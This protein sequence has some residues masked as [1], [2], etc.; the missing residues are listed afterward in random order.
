[1]TD[2]VSEMILDADGGSTDGTSSTFELEMSLS[3][4]AVSLS[5]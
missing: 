2:G 4:Y 5:S 1:M 3:E